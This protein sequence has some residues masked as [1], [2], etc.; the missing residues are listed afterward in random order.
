MKSLKSLAKAKISWLTKV[1][2]IGSFDYDIKDLY[3]RK[4]AKRVLGKKILVACFPKSGSTYL[5]KTLQELLHLKRIKMVR[6]FGNSE[7]ELYEP[8]LLNA[9]ETDGVA[10][11]HFKPTTSN[12]DLLKRY[13]IKPVILTRNIFDVVPSIK[14]HHIRESLLTPIFFLT[15]RYKSM[16]DEDRFDL[17]I[18][19]GIP[20]YIYFYASWY[21]V[22][23]NKEIDTCW[24]TYEELM[25]DRVGTID[26]IVKFCG[27]DCSGQEIEKTIEYMDTNK[28][29]TRFNKGAIGRGNQLSEEQKEKIRAFTRFYPEVDFSK[30]GL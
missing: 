26:K 29:K 25:T 9:F 1:T 20:W 10:Q 8:Y 6:L 28:E 27:F 11:L 14:D 12:M 17:I 15:D 2:K 13:D 7:Q 4:K 18:E 19:L 21:M 23:Q 22:V 16:S 30:M 5:S 3:N 24:V